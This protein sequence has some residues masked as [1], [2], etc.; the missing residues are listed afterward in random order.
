MPISI[1][2]VGA[3]DYVNL[4]LGGNPSPGPGQTG[5]N[6]RN[7]NSNIDNKLRRDIEA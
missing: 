6:R 5:S 3:S 2:G 1:Q 4:I 7:K